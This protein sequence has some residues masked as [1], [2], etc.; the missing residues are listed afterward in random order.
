M[1]EKLG[2]AYYVALRPCV[3]TLILQMMIT[4][5]IIV[6]IVMMI[7]M[8]IHLTALS[9]SDQLLEGTTTNPLAAIGIRL[10]IIMMMTII[11][12]RMMMMMIMD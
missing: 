10:M 2:G 8:M 1:R 5:I 4:M 7:T 3:K 9:Y 6:V 12:V 11:I